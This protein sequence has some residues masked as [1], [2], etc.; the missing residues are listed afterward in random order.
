MGNLIELIESSEFSY[1]LRTI[2]N[3]KLADFTVAFAVDFETAGE[4][5]TA[6]L[7]GSKFFSFDLCAGKSVKWIS[8]NLAHVLREH[9]ATCLNVAGNGI[10]TLSRF[11]IT[12]PDINQII[13]EI[14]REVHGEWPLTKIVSGGQ[15]GVDFAALVAAHRLG[16]PI[17]AIFP[18]G[19]RQRGQDSQDFYN[20]RKTIVNQI[21]ED[22]LR[23]N[24]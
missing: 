23:L 11:N 17:T 4:K 5:L 1:K 8:E 20:T 21:I 16:I 18:S 6:K 24:C 13:F 22:S 7:A 19:F 10:Y 12:Q 2:Q 3:I 15:T 14:L 9:N